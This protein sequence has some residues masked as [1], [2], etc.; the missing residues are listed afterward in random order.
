MPG[1]GD[2]HVGGFRHV[3]QI[4]PEGV[5]QRVASVSHVAVLPV[6][7]REAVLDEVRTLLA[8]HPAVRGLDVVEIP[9]RVDAFWAERVGP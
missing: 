1:F 2:L 5:V 9:Y 7:E 3:Q 4:T 8:S 6:P